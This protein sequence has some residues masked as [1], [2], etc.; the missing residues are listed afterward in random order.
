MVEDKVEPR[1]SNGRPRFLWTEIFQ[2]FRI[3]LDFNKLI[4]AAAGILVM[5]IGWWLLANIF[6]YSR[7]EFDNK[8]YPPRRSPAPTNRNGR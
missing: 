6:N 3:A 7:P 1:P 5:A 2:G 8:N 4:L